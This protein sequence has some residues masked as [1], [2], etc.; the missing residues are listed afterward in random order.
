MAVS[1][2]IV[3]GAHWCPDCRRAKSFL[4]DH[5]IPYVWVN[6][7]EDEAAEQL[8]IRLNEG[9]RIIPTIVFDDGTRLVEPSN[10]ELAAKLGLKTTVDRKFWPLICIGAGPA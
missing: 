4:G 2:P 6:I 7:E 3:Y 9:K 8:V 1:S 5:Q 10:A